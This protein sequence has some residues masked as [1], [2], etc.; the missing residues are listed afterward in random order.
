MVSPLLSLSPHAHMHTRTHSPTLT[1]THSH[2]NAHTHTRA[3]TTAAAAAAKDS[4]RSGVKERDSR[5]SQLR[6]SNIVFH[7]DSDKFSTSEFNCTLMRTLWQSSIETMSNEA[8]K[9]DCCRS[10]VTCWSHNHGHLSLTIVTL[11]IQQGCLIK[12]QSNG[13]TKN[14]MKIHL[15]TFNPH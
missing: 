1:Y 13:C 9:R 8:I 11:N 14:I 4:L 10:R 7:L 15:K 12:A 5:P 2:A 6:F 3:T